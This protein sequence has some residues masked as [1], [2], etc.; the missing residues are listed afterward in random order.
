MCVC[1]LLQKLTNGILLYITSGH[2]YRKVK[3]ALSQQVCFQ[4]ILLN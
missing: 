4:K 1:M 3:V 2:A